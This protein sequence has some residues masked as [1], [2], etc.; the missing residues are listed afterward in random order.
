MCVYKKQRFHLIY[1][2]LI[3]SRQF[4]SSIRSVPYFEKMP[5]RFTL[6]ADVMLLSSRP[7][8]PDC[9][10]T[11]KYNSIYVEERLY[12]ILHHTAVKV[13]VIAEL[14]TSSVTQSD[15]ISVYVKTL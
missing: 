3:D 5:Q 4:R 9:K 14:L 12:C 8:S 10:N 11:S 6:Y 13:T 15:W 7:G 2:S 1:S